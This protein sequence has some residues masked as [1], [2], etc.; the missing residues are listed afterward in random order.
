LPKS[1]SLAG[2]YAKCLKTNSFWTKDNYYQIKGGTEW[3]P[4]GVLIKDNTASCWLA[5]SFKD[6][7]LMPEGFTP[8]NVVPEYVEYIGTEYKGQIAKVIEWNHDTWCKVKLA[9]GT[10]LVP[11]KHLVKPSTKETYEAQQGV[12]G[13]DEFVL[14]EKWCIKCTKENED[15]LTRWREFDTSISIGRY[16]HNV[17]PNCDKRGVSHSFIKEGYTEITFEQFKKYVLKEKVEEK[18]IPKVGDW[19]FETW[20]SSPFFGIPFQITKIE[21]KRIWYSRKEVNKDC[22]AS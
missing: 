15:Y 1:K 22:E 4:N 5:E 10:R 12:K 16:M 7:E 3:K 8:E 19:V 14:P 9:D 20:K 2:R 17:Y 21:E 11:F 18:W 13:V 6:F